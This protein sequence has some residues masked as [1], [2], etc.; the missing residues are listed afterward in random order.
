MRLFDQ[1]SNELTI[2][3]LQHFSI[4]NHGPCRNGQHR[5]RGSHTWRA[6]YHSPRKIRQIAQ[7][8]C[9]A[10]AA[11]S[12][13]AR[14]TN[15]GDCPSQ[16]LQRSTIFARWHRE[17]N[18]FRVGS[19]VRKRST[20]E[21]PPVQ[22]SHGPDLLSMLPADRLQPRTSLPSVSGKQRSLLRTF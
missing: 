13:P 18:H 12:V 6:A 3:N 19:T 4:A 17:C 20:S 7:R 5:P 21:Y 15:S 14:W 1:I 2:L 9:P 16:V 8:H 11:P 22:P 10:Q